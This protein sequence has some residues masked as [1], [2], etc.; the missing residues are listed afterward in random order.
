MTPF[1][2]WGL[3]RI[4]V[5]QRLEDSSNI[6]A[7][8]RTFYDTTGWALRDGIRFED[9]AR[10]EDLRP[11]A[12]EYVHRCHLRVKEHLSSGGCALLDVASGP[13]QFD[14]Y[15]E[16]GAG[17]GYR[18]CVDLSLAALRKARERIGTRGQYVVADIT[19]LPFRGDA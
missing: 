12:A 2:H 6:K 14:E 7:A 1:V 3:Q 10:F 17:Y 8:V 11:V 16:Y 18:V 5:E 15:L 9:A 19:N 4:E 13:L